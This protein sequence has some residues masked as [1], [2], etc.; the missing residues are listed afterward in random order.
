MVLE[1]NKNMET[2]SHKAC[3]KGHLNVLELLLHTDPW[4]ASLVNRYQETLI[5]VATR[6][7]H[8]H[9]VKHLLNNFPEILPLEE[10][11]F[12]TSL[13]VAASEGHTE[14]VKSIIEVR[15][16]FAWG[17]DIQGC[18][19][20]HLACNNGHLEITRELLRLDPDLSCLQ[21]Q[22]NGGRTPLHLAAIRGQ[23]NILDEILSASQEPVN[24]L[25]A[26]RETALH[27]AV[28]NNQFDATKF[29]VEKVNIIDLVNF[30]NKDGD[31]I[32][33][34]AMA[35]RLYRLKVP[36]LEAFNTCVH[37]MISSINLTEMDSNML[38][39][40]NIKRV[41]RY[42]DCHAVNAVNHKG[43]TALDVSLREAG[44]KMCSKLSLES[45]QI[46][47][48]SRPLEPTELIGLTT[49]AHN[50]QS[51]L[52]QSSRS[53]LKRQAS[54]ISETPSMGELETLRSGGLIS[55]TTGPIQSK[56]EG[57]GVYYPC[58][59]E[60]NLHIE[61]LQNDRNTITIVAVLIA[62]VTFTAGFNP[63]GGVYQDGLLIGRST[64]GRSILFKVFMICNNLALFL[65]LGIVIV[66]V[67]VVPFTR[68]SLTKL[69]AWNHKAL[70]LSV[71]FMA[72]AYMAGSWII[73]P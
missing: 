40:Y 63:P 20:L 64:R 3:L 36:T 42:G 46:P 43:L 54:E 12:T 7:G 62:S 19:P 68:K 9:V 60:L 41:G 21:E 72:M 32:L 53:L 45:P 57:Q 23:V 17:K 39:I 66:L 55:R 47:Q 30:P 48:L 16:D 24:I 67:S 18:T 4:V 49:Q 34:L 11:R 27:L 71:S 22:D 73:I 33:H 65:S 8:A 13:H 51:E 50:W 56:L 29:L 5:F 14:I 69:L 6:R 26:G 15:Q 1:Q 58:Q 52:L 44:G 25:T 70:W 28:K 59:K 31:T 38:V 10:D 37:G 35:R 2:P 61:G